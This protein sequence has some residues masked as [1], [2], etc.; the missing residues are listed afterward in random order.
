M[1]VWDYN[2]FSIIQQTFTFTF[3]R[4]L[5]SSNF[6]SRYYDEQGLE[7]VTKVH[8]SAF[9]WSSVS[10]YDILFLMAAGSCELF[11]PRMGGRPSRLEGHHEHLPWTT[12]GLYKVLWFHSLYIPFTVLGENILLIDI[13][14]HDGSTSFFHTFSPCN[15]FNSCC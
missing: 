12:V 5:L 1:H 15:L 10:V 9:V 4:Q 11:L 7:V 8:P 6:T 13:N 14:P 3:N 2:Q